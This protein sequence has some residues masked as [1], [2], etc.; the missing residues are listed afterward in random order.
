[1]TS[2]FTK[3]NISFITGRVETSSRTTVV[4]CAQIFRRPVRVLSV[5]SVLVKVLKKRFA[6]STRLVHSKHE[7]TKR[8]T[9]FVA[10]YIS[11]TMCF[12]RRAERAGKAEVS[13]VS[14]PTSSD[15][16]VPDEKN[17]NGR[18]FS[19]TILMAMSS[20]TLKK[21]ARQQRMSGD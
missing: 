7:T 11:T 21:R 5:P 2:P 4:S 12:T 19:T 13:A 20:R 8:L 18:N 10:T 6:C 16:A 3:T 9:F 17:M 1:M 15:Q 14:T